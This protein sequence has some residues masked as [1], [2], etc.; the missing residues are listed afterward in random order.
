MAIPGVHDLVFRVVQQHI[1]P[2]DDF[3]VLD[4]GAGMGAFSQTLSEA[5]YRVAACD[6]FPELFRCPGV[7]CRQA[8]VERPLPY[9]DNSFEAVV[10]LE[11]VEH[12]ETQ[13]G[14][15]A[16]VERI[17]KPGGTFLFS[18]PNVMSL[19]S[20]VRFLLTGYMYSHGPLDPTVYD[21][22]SQHVA[23]FSPD[24]YQFMLARAG[25]K[26]TNVAADKYQRTSLWL[27]WLSPLVR[28]CARQ[29]FGDSPG[30]RMQ[31]CPA[32]L[33]GRT[34]IGVAQKPCEAL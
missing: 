18:T 28:L 24:R 32:A 4:L 17:L 30:V 34:M 12:L 13:L 6:M 7:E 19:K 1:P 26:L 33:L 20:R 2:N 27:S 16:E 8:D 25:L 15:F 22:V 21:P 10:A 11:V 23:P 29:S 9:D 31:N 5:G 14:L 3:R